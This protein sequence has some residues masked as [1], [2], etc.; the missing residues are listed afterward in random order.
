MNMKKFYTLE[1]IAKLFNCDA[2][3]LT[4]LAAQSLFPVC[5]VANNWYAHV[6]SK[7]RPND[8]NS[9]DNYLNEEEDI[10]FGD[11]VRFTPLEKAIQLN[12]AFLVLK[13]S[14]L[15]AYQ[16]NETANISSFEAGDLMRDTDEY[17]FE[18]R[19]CNPSDFSKPYEINLKDHK[20]V[21]MDG[22]L[23]RI[24]K[25][26][27]DDSIQ[28]EIG[29]SD[30]E[31]KKLLKI[32]G[33]LAM[34]ITYSAKKFQIKDKVNVS[35]ISNKLLDT[36]DELESKEIIINKIG[37]SDTTLRGII[38]KGIDELLNN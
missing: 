35:Q 30:S 19:L 18:Y 37:L 7:L 3:I 16:L 12:N 4:N 17:F 13:P 21:V 33:A 6:W 27:Q 8:D 1:E 29:L 24:K 11:W 31:R 5:I 14:S 15:I 26:L 9:F 10:D 25:I 22:C 2:S 32:I 38:K 23:P 20:L 36:F 28:N 34:D